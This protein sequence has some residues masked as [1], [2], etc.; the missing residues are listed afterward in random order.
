MTAVYGGYWNQL[1]RIIA[2]GRRSTE[3]E[4][5]HQAAVATTQAGLKK[6]KTGMK[7]GEV[8]P[9]MAETA[10]VYG[11]GLTTPMGHFAG[12]D[13]VEARVDANSRVILEPGIAVILHPRLDDFRGRR[14]LLWGET[15]MMADRGPVRLNETDDALHTV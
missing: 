12:L 10:K 13:L 15:Y 5:F 4:K 9:F 2:V 6:M 1:V 14:I 7:M 8:I 11:F 3:L